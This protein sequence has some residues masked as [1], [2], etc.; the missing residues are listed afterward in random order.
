M[1]RWQWFKSQSAFFVS[2]DITLYIHTS[3][4]CYLP[5]LLM[6]GA[7]VPEISDASVIT[8][9]K[10]HKI[11]SER[12]KLEFRVILPHAK[13]NFHLILL[14]QKQ[15]TAL[16][17]VYIIDTG[18][19]IK[20]YIRQNKPKVTPCHCCVPVFTSH[21]FHYNLLM[22]ILELELTDLAS[23]ETQW[24]DYSSSAVWDAQS[25]EE[26]RLKFPCSPFIDFMSIMPKANQTLASIWLQAGRRSHCIFALH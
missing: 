26:P 18:H 21:W 8:L 7:S 13:E 6:S 12:V 1:W 9:Y 15:T 2:P 24:W 17:P 14:K 10:L 11:D 19:E 25:A 3:C 16:P 4:L 5:T 23:L 20:P 22:D